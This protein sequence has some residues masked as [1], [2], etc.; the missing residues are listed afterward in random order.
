MFFV[1]RGRRYRAGV[2]LRVQWG[3]AEYWQDEGNGQ[4]SH[5]H[6]LDDN[7]DLVLQ[8][9][10]LACPAHFTV[11]LDRNKEWVLI[12]DLWSVIVELESSAAKCSSSG[13]LLISVISRNQIGVC[14]SHRNPSLRQEPECPRRYGMRDTVG[15]GIWFS[16]EGQNIVIVQ[17]I[18]GW[19]H[20][21]MAPTITG[22]QN[23][24]RKSDWE[25]S[26]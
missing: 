13:A 8:P 26:Y 21:W 3:M 23:T 9:P 24:T 17:K 14:T 2:V 6:F 4:S 18:T 22:I 5:A 20:C 15:E 19:K 1:D 7:I 10:M 16:G 25:I 12:F 11:R